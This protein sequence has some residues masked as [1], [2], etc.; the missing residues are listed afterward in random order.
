MELISE[1]GPWSSCENCKFGKGYKIRKGFCRIK[2]K[3]NEVKKNYL[4]ILKENFFSFRKINLV[5]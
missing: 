3:I 1:W 4:F 2:T 5:Q